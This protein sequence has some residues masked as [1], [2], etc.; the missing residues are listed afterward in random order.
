MEHRNQDKWEEMN[1]QYHKWFRFQVIV[2]ALESVANVCCEDCSE[3]I[4]VIAKDT[5]KDVYR[6]QCDLEKAIEEYDRSGD[7]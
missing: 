4:R 6:S 7:E 1:D 2:D 5:R 3:M